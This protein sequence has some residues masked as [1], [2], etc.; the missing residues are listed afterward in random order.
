MKNLT[1]LFIFDNPV[2]KDP[3]YKFWLADHTSLKKLD[4]LEIKGFVWERLSALKQNWN[5]E[6]L[7][8]STKEEYYKRI[9]AEWEIKQSALDLLK[10]QTESV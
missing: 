3:A 6:K 2:S 9:E 10:K 7:V 5:M 4:G 8:D 1:E